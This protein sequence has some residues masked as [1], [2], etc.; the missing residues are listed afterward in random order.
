MITAPICEF[1]RRY[2]YSGALRMHM[3]GH[4]GTALLGPEP[5]DLTEIEDAD[6]LYH[7]EGIIRE[8]E[9]NAAALFGTKK[10]VYSAEGSSLCIRAMLYLALL[11]ARANHKK[12]V[13]AAG[14]NA[15]KV[16]MTAAALL[17]LDIRWIYGTESVISCAITPAQLEDVIV[18]ENPAAVY[19]TSPDYLG[20]IAD[21]KSLS[22][23]CK[24]HGV[25]LLV[26]NAH[27]AYLHFLPEPMHP[28]Q[29]GADICCDSAHKTLPVL[30]GGAYLHIAHGTPD[31]FAQRAESAM[32]LFASTSP[33]YLILQSLDATNPL[34]ATSFPA[35]L[36]ACAERLDTLKAKLRAHGYALCGE[37]R[38]KLCL[39]PKSF[40]YTGTVLAEI[41]TH[42]NIYCEFSDADHLVMMFT[43]ETTPADFA[44]LERALLSVLPAPA[45]LSKPPVPPHAERVLSP[46]EALFSPSETL[47]LSECENRILADANVSCPP[48]VPLAVCGERLTPE[49]ISAMEYYGTEHCTVVV[50]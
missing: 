9:A 17:D 4:K 15:H 47:P 2:R 1:V 22:T 12:P 40:G 43:P 7:A 38:T 5:L 21:I 3:P 18:S 41:L 36:K 31:M 11:H 26:D 23:V 37:E 48:A 30:T 39:L 14:R 6:V 32:A 42:H 27:G 24:K 8:S 29:L 10:T 20:N 19:I 28:M 33:S 50:E 25:L 44:R 13:I 46:R 49:V 45:I 35:Q 34:L 16:F